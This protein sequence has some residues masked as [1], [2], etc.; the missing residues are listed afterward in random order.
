MGYQCCK[1]VYKN[2]LLRVSS[3]LRWWGWGSL[4]CASRSGYC[5]SAGFTSTHPCLHGHRCAWNSTCVT[6]TFRSSLHMTRCCMLFPDRCSSCRFYWCCCRVHFV[7]QNSS[8]KSFQ[9]ARLICQSPF[10]TEDISSILLGSEDGDA[11]AGT[12][13]FKN[14]KQYE[15]SEWSGERGS[16]AISAT[17]EGIEAITCN[18]EL[19]KQV[20]PMFGRVHIKRYR[21]NRL[22]TDYV[23][24]Q[25]PCG[26]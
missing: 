3:C 14:A 25:N 12:K 1:E 15:H 19:K 6:L 8:T 11:I 23:L 20:F 24:G 9:S 26:L 5:I 16:L 7:D 17:N 22:C 21:R 10:L 2:S 4:P 13:S 18:T